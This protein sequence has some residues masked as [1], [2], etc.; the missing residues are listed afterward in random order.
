MF[1]PPRRFP[2]RIRLSGAEAGPRGVI[3]G[4][5]ALIERIGIAA[6]LVKIRPMLY[7][8]WEIRV[9]LH[10]IG[11]V[12][13]PHPLQ[14]FPDDFPYHLPQLGICLLFGHRPLHSFP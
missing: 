10:P 14:L 11:I 7:F 2:S 13:V 1:R 12:R 3:R 6:A 4:Q 5:V 9:V 8:G